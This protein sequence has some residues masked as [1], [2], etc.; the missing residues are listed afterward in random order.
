M[1]LLRL[2]S[3]LAALGL[4]LAACGGGDDEE[5]G[6]GG[7]DGEIAT[8]PGFDGET[9]RLGIL[10]PLSGPVAVIGE[11]L[12]AGNQVWFDYL[13]EEEGGIAGRYPVELVTQDTL[14][15]TDT[16]VQRY[17][18][19]KN[20]VTMFTQL[21]GTP[22]TLATLPSLQRDNITAAPAS[23]DA[24]WVREPNLLPVGGPYQVQAINALDYYRSE[25]GEDNTICGMFQDDVYGEAGEAGVD[26]A[27][28]NGGFEVATKEEFQAGDENFTG[29]VQ[30]LR[31]S[32]CDAVFLTAL[33]TEV[34]AILGTAA[35]LE[36]APRWILQSP[37]WIDELAESPLAEY[38]AQTTWVASEGTEWGDTEVQG[39]ADM[40][41]RVE[42]YAPEQEPDYYFA[43]GYIQARAV[44]ALLEQAVENG[45]LSRDGIQEA[46]TQLGTVSFDG[47]SGDYDYGEGGG[48]EN[49]NPPRTSTIFEVD[50]EKPF[51]LGTLEYQYTSDAAEQIEFT[52]RAE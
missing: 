24:F 29:Q 18:Q 37:G 3:V 38:L 49:R 9:I 28:E 43:F 23:L 41:Q 1:K 36:F 35:R 52:E 2:L 17:N 51:G 6:G 27:A 11:P 26:F 46:M 30:S 22:P 32:D 39:M 8:A 50:P 48:A 33:P 21:L 16:T 15:E 47:L 34:G 4:F 45:D 12:T 20:D 31:Q 19:I 7:G 14:Y 13:N 10:S 5:S 25:E 44:T 40:V 42:R